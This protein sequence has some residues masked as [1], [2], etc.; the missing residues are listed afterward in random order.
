MIDIPYLEWH[1][2]DACNF[3]CRGCSHMSD[4]KMTKM[5]TVD[6]LRSWFEP[7]HR[8]IRPHMISILGGEPL[9]NKQ[10]ID[11]LELC[12]EYW[13][14][15]HREIVTNGWLLH[16]WPQLPKILDQHAIS[17]VIS[18]HH[19]SEEY[20]NEFQRIRDLVSEWKQQYKNLLT[21][22]FPS[23]VFWTQAFQGH[24]TDIKPWPGDDAETSWDNCISGQMCFHLRDSKIYKCAQ[25]ANLPVLDQHSSLG[26]EWQPYLDYRPLDPGAS[27]QEVRDFFQRQAEPV[28]SMCNPQPVY[29]I[30]PDPVRR[31]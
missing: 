22:W 25:L 28:C 23:H 1:I 9:L 20:M 18:R 29:Y 21:G 7:W 13:P 26:S 15:S 4:V 6:E 14:Q 5:M 24:G 2:T 12:V 16:R 10:L 31:G 8:R 17:L 19:T 27:D 3:S 11:I 30:K